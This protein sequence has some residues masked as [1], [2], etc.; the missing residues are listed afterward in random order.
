MVANVLL[1]HRPG[2]TCPIGKASSRHGGSQLVPWIDQNLATIRE[3]E[4]RAIAGFSMGAFVAVRHAA[5]RPG[6]FRFVLGMSGGY[7]LEDLRMRSAVTGSMAIEEFPPDG[8]FGAPS[9][10]SW[11]VNNPWHRVQALRDTDTVLYAGSYPR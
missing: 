2:N 1:H 4:G 6:L 10:A 5:H 3:R 8:A 9:D 11:N 7:D